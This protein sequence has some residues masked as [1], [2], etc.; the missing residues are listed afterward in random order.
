MG[1]KGYLQCGRSDCAR[2]GYIWKRYKGHVQIPLRK[3]ITGVLEALDYNAKNFY[4]QH[5][6][7][8]FNPP[9]EAQESSFNID[10]YNRI[11]LFTPHNRED[12]INFEQ[13]FMK[14]FSNNID[15]YYPE[16]SKTKTKTNII[17]DLPID[18]N[19]NNIYKLARETIKNETTRRPNRISI[20]C[21]FCSISFAS[22]RDIYQKVEH[23]YVPNL[24][25]NYHI[26]ELKKY[27]QTL[28]TC[29]IIPYYYVEYIF[30]NKYRI[31]QFDILNLIR[32]SQDYGSRAA[33]SRNAHNWLFCIT[34]LENKR[35]S[36][37]KN[38]KCIHCLNSRKKM[39]KLDSKS[40]QT[41]YFNIKNDMYFYYI[42]YLTL[43]KFMSII[44]NFLKNDYIVKEEYFSHFN[45]YKHQ[46]SNS[47]LLYLR[48]CHYQIRHYD[49][50]ILPKKKIHYLTNSEILNTKVK[51]HEYLNEIIMQSIN[52]P[53]IE[54]NRLIDILTRYRFPDEIMLEKILKDLKDFQIIVPNIENHTVKIKNP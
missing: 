26:D 39:T 49:A 20:F 9:N 18:Y 37:I 25:S 38:G 17:A 52:Y 31:S 36:F 10:E 11:I 1:K 27:Y 15:F 23:S 21:L 46:I 3:N 12:I 4:K 48:K 35:I 43:V 14:I 44:T 42:N 2:R 53:N 19:N 50:T 30:N 5:E 22:L 45:R 6:H 24:S 40:I 47:K 16:S 7:L 13:R 54:T 33:S 34:C 32:D 51:D 41:M 29:L 8:T 28:A